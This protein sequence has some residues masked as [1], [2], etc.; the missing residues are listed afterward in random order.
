MHLNEKRLAAAIAGR[1]AAD[2]LLALA[3]TFNAE[4]HE[5]FQDRYEQAMW[6]RL[7][8]EA[9]KAAPLPVTAPRRGSEPMTAAQARE[10]EKVPMPFGKY[11]GTP[12]GD[13]YEEDPGYLDYLLNGD[14]FK[15]QLN[16]YLLADRR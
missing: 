1:Q 12:V 7:R 8:D 2:E 10:F 4:D 16:R 15:V 6:E 13:V 3:G 14:D 9:L 11:E 5:P